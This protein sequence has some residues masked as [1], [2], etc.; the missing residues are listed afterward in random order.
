M[1]KNPTCFINSFS[2]GK[3]QFK[4]SQVTSAYTKTTSSC[5]VCLSEEDSIILWCRGR[6]IRKEEIAPSDYTSSHLSIHL[7]R[8]ELFFSQENNVL[9]CERSRRQCCDFIRFP[10]TGSGFEYLVTKQCFYVGK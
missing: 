8:V 1:V 7:P 2:S 10:I 4:Q 5:S 6:G 9:S 3:A